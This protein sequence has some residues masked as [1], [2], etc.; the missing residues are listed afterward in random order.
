MNLEVDLPRIYEALSPA[1]RGFVDAVVG[2]DGNHLSYGNLYGPRWRS[3]SD[4]VERFFAL[5]LDTRLEALSYFMVPIHEFRHHFDMLTTPFGACVHVMALDEYR[6]F[7]KMSAVIVRKLDESD[8][9]GPKKIVSLDTWLQEHDIELDKAS[10]KNWRTLANLMKVLE[11]WGDFNHIKSR[12]LEP[13]PDPDLALPLMADLL[14]PVL[15]NGLFETFTSK[16][17]EPWDICPGDWF[18]T[19]STILEGRAVLACLLWSIDQLQ[20]H[21]EAGKTLAEWVRRTY[22]ADQDR[23]Y[24]FLIDLAASW[25]SRPT[26]EELLEGHPSIERT[27]AM[28]RIINMGAWVALQAPPPRPNENAKRCN[29]CIRLYAALRHA[30]L[31]FMTST[32]SAFTC[33]DFTTRFDDSTTARKWQYS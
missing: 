14:K 10:R 8:A 13:F 9:Q 15:V 6:R 4:V 28:L 17:R 30:Q 21:P 7:Q 11:A 27:A 33:D 24:R 3:R 2:S 18:L 31:L 20:G 16:Q 25:A 5:S 29:P 22:G 19:P 1:A 26:V 23:D 12:E 32:E